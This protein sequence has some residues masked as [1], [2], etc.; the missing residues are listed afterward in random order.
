MQDHTRIIDLEGVLNFRD[1][2]GY[3]AADGRLVR[4][5]QIFRSAE[6]SGLTDAD[7]AAVEAL[8]IKAVF[9]LRSNEERAARP[10]AQQPLVHVHPT[11][12]RK[13][14]Y[15]ASHASR[16]IGMPTEE[17]RALIRE[18]IAHATQP[19]FVYTHIWLVGDR[20]PL[21]RHS[22]EG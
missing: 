8:G 5:G 10:P 14:L 16:I 7:L 17:G 2:G 11:S 21:T 19:Q 3:K 20:S 1:L 4:K 12:G 18:M 9:D 13:V 22:D 6:L 15:V